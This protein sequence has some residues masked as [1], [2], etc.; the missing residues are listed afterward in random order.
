M[1]SCSSS[2]S[3]SLSRASR[4]AYR[5]LADRSRLLVGETRRADEKQGLALVGWQLR[6]RHAEFLEFHAA[7]LVGMR[8]QTLRVAA[9]G[10]FD[11]TTP[12]A[13]FR[14]EQVAEDGESQA[15]MCDPGW[16]ELMLAMARKSVSCTRSS[17]RSTLPLSEIAN[18]RKPG[19]AASMASRTAGE[20]SSARSL[21]V[22]V[23]ESLVGA[24]GRDSDAAIIFM[25]DLWPRLA[26]FPKKTR[27]WRSG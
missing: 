17:A 7:V 9:V 8:L 16:N 23:V 25:D 6:E 13:V 11:L 24:P 21:V 12:L 5:A 15:D 27:R 1:A 20:A 3:R 4:S 14:A 26:G 10:V 19:T 18:A 2:V 22:R